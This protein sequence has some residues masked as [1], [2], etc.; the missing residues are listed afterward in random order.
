MNTETESR[1]V[2]SCTTTLRLLQ[3]LLL[4]LLGLLAAS[5]AWAVG[6]VVISQVYGGGG[7]SGY[8]KYD[9]VELYN[10]TDTAVDVS[11]WSIQ[12]GSATGIVGQNSS[13]VVP[14]PSRAG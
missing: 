2:Q 1:K 4:S 8:Y 6:D 10:R 7:G 13:F 5:S 11:T 12:Y 14:Q 9:Y 3:V